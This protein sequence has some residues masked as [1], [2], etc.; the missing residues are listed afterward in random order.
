MSYQE[1]LGQKTIAISISE[2][3]DMPVLGLGDEHL[4]D[5]MAEMARHLLALGAR[6]IYG[7]DLRQYG[8]TNLLF[9]L[10]ARHRRDADEDDSRTGVTNYLAWPVHI[11]Q[12]VAALETQI[13]EVEDSAEIVCLRIDGGRLPIEE[14]RGLPSQ[15][16]TEQEWADGLTSMRITMMS[17]SDARVVVGGRVEGYKGAMPGI[18]EEVLISLKAG[19]PVFLIGG[20]GGCTCDIAETMGLIKPRTTSIPTWAG[21]TEFAGFTVANLNNGL[22]DEENATLAYT[23]HVD[24][25]ITLILRGMM[26]LVKTEGSEGA[27]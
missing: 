7:G 20:F 8:F 4:Q 23:P 12:P 10:V 2:S 13:V 1:V 24:Q 5:A 15:V 19:K 16:P 22:T 18:A 27:P 11:Q 26:Q 14:R 9:E 21:R 3:P 25:A 17:D 6:L